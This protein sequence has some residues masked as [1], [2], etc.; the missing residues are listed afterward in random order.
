MF[1]ELSLIFSSTKNVEEAVSAPETISVDEGSLAATDAVSDVMLIQG[2][3]GL[4]DRSSATNFVWHPAVVRQLLQSPIS[5]P[6]LGC[7]VL[8]VNARHTLQFG[9]EFPLKTIR[10]HIYQARLRFD[11][12]SE[13]KA[14]LCADHL[15]MGRQKELYLSQSAT[16][17]RDREHFESLIFPYVETRLAVSVGEQAAF[18]WRA[19][20]T[21]VVFELFENT[22]LH[23]RTDWTGRVL[24]NSIRGLLFR[25]TLVHPFQPGTRMAQEAIRCLEIG[26]FD[27][28]VGYYCKNQKKSLSDEVSVRDEWDVLH[29]CLSTHLEDGVAPNLGKGQRGIGLYEVLRALKFLNGAI[30]FR[31]GRLHAYRSF[32]PGDLQLQMESKESKLRPNMPKPTL[33]DYSRKFIA[34]PTEELKV[35]GTA[36]RVLVPFA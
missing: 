15:G 30:E 22:D 16:G 3:I 8:H 25:D 21:S 36:V 6:L 20:L 2:V 34:V 1:P 19:A 14:L 33:L 24:H 10:A 23:G 17:I 18:K 29:R 31:T 28:G 27:S 13:P 11:W 12:F 4:L 32:L 9:E 5:F 7:L 35:V 26:V